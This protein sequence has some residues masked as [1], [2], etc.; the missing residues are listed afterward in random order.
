[1]GTLFAI[2]W[3]RSLEYN[4]LPASLMG[5]PGSKPTVYS[6][7]H[8]LNHSIILLNH[9]FENMVES[10]ISVTVTSTANI[11]HFGLPC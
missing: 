3:V 8:I 4:V 10:S 7:V 2:L 5:D 1:M 6:R 11:D 9:I